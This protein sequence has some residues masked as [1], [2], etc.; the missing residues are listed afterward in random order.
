MLCKAVGPFVVYSI[1]DYFQSIDH[2]PYYCV[3]I[4]GRKMNIALKKA[5]KDKIM[6]GGGGGEN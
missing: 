6:E 4:I 3:V 2:V 5:E 1:Y